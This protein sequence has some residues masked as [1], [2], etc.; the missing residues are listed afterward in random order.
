MLLGRAR[1][2]KLQEIM[3]SENF[4]NFGVHF[5]KSRKFSSYFSQVIRKIDMNN[6]ILGLQHTLS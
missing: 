1:L 5:E 3:T 4:S 2:K 6:N